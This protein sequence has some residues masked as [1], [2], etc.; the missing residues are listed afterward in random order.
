MAFDVG[1][2]AK[3][4]KYT[5]RGKEGFDINQTSVGLSKQ[6][7]IHQGTA[8]RYDGDD[9]PMKSTRSQKDG[10]KDQTASQGLDST[11]S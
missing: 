1:R 9:H 2:Q 11:A 5:T 4:T 7:K 3:V 8:K 6:L 10:Q